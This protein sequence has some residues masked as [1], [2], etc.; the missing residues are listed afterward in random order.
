MAVF[1]SV[2]YLSDALTV[3]GTLCKGWDVTL[4][5]GTGEYLARPIKRRLIARYKVPIDIVND[6][7]SHVFFYAPQRVL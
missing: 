2:R 1:D 5:S 4:M 3:K 6:A 7:E